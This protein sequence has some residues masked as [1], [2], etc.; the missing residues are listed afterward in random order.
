MSEVIDTV[1]VVG[2]GGVASQ[3]V[4]CLCRYLTYAEDV[5]VSPKR[6][7]IV[8]GDKVS[9]KNLSRQD[10]D[11]DQVGSPKSLA[12]SSLL[13]EKW[14]ALRFDHFPSYVTPDNVRIIEDGCIVLLAVDNHATRKLVEDHVVGLQEAILISGGNDLHQG[15]V[16]V[17]SVSEGELQSKTMQEL[18]PEIANPSD[19]RPDEVGC[20][21]NFESEPQSLIANNMVAALMM[22]A[23]W[24]MVVLGFV[25]YYEV[26]F[27]IA[28]NSA[29]TVD[30]CFSGASSGV[31]RL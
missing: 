7:V 26:N 30:R 21:E 17:V 16:H 28:T 19:R 8:D 10:Y 22:N 12:M 9:E 11:P 2:A 14:P 25:P 27:D 1:Y 18:H 23:F 13:E 5:L 29:V 6:V 20:D 15:S 31:R 3:F 4:D 24:S